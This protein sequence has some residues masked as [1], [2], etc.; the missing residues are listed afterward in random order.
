MNEPT[1]DELWE[2]K[3]AVIT[4]FMAD[5]RTMGGRDRLWNNIRQQYPEISRRD[6]ARALKEDPI[7]QIHQPLNKR[8]T[9]RPIIA[10]DRAKMVGIDLID[11]QKIAGKNDGHRYILSYVDMLSKYAAARPIRTKTQVNVIRA[12]EDILDSMPAN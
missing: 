6:V 8:I 2:L 1:P 9:T 12:L 11:F 4:E 7:T 3:K 5:P 10:S